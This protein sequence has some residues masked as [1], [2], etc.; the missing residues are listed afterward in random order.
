KT[1][2]AESEYI[3]RS[4]PLLKQWNYTV[5]GSL[6]RLVD[7]GFYTI[8]LSRNMFFN[9]ADRYENNAIASGE[10]LFQL[11]SHEIENKLRF[12]MNKYLDG[13]KVTYGASGQY[14]KYDASLFNTIT[15]DQVDDQGNVI[16]P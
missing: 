10:K 11:G 13:W 3:L 7:D 1:S 15:R 2:D 6:K 4:N 12:D 5:G 16:Q 14:V 9:G 8:A